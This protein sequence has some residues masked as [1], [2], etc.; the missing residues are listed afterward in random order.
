MRVGDEVHTRFTSIFMV[1]IPLTL[2]AGS[3]L[4]PVSATIEAG[5]VLLSDTAHYKVC[6]V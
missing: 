5:F 6:R 2:V 1:Y 4:P 3:L